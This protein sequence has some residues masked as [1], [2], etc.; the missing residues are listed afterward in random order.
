ML[1][2]DPQLFAG[3]AWLFSDPRLDRHIDYLFID[4][5]GQV[6]LAQVISAGTSARNLILLGDPMQL[7][8]PSKGIHPEG[9]GLS[10][11]E[12]IQEERATISPDKGIFMNTSRRLHSSLCK[13][14]SKY[15]YEGRLKSLPENDHRTVLVADTSLHGIRCIPVCHSGNSNYSE[16]EAEAVTDL[17][18]S[19][20]SAKY[21]NGD[22]ISAVTPED[23]LVVAPYN[24]QVNL[25]KKRIAPLAPEAR[26]GTIDKFQGQEAP[27]VIVS[28]TTSSEEEISRSMDFLF[29]RNRLNVALSRA[30]SLAFVVMCPDLL[31]V[32]CNTVEQMKLVNFLCAVERDAEQTMCGKL[33]FLNSPKHPAACV[34]S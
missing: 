29:S 30:T 10:V 19:L 21:K 20:L 13:F 25:L 8:Q 7:P 33:I 4:E 5:A 11:L 18:R 32:R 23:I 22:K 17:Y 28:M 12:Y 9:I 26:A 24:L 1:Q 31:R 34:R 14:I 16:Q 2:A 6:S 3:T 27:I 15:V